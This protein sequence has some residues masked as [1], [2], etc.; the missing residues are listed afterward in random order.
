VWLLPRANEKW[1]RIGVIALG[2]LLTIG[3]FARGR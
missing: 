3:L 2:I 1:L